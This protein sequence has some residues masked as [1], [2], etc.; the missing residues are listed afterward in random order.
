VMTST[1]TWQVRRL[2][3]GG[4][5]VPAMEVSSGS[6]RGR[7][8]EAESS[9]DKL[10]KTIEYQKGVVT[11]KQVLAS[12]LSH[13]VLHRRVGTGRRWQ[14]LLPGIYLTVTGTPT[15]DQLDIAALLYG[16]PGSTLT[17]VSALRRHGLSN[18]DS[19]AVHVLVPASRQRRSTGYV[20]VHRTRRLPPLVCYEGPVQFA[21]PARAVGDAARDSRDLAD[22][23]AMVAACVQTRRCTVE[24]LAEELATGPIRR[25]RLF[26]AAL[27]EV[28]DGTRSGPE[29]ELRDLIRKGRLPAPMWNPRLYHGT[30]FLARPDAWW[31]EAAVA[32]EVDSRQWHLSPEHWEQTMGRHARMTSLGILV[33]H[34]S[35][36]QIR[37]EPHDVLATIRTALLSRRGQPTPRIRAV[38]AAG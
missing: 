15:R 4:G 20:A 30:T 6:R 23:R 10:A 36:R 31:P 8:C 7:A 32:V 19:S 24:Q 17:G 13:Q 27:A 11:R 34:F 5:N 29:A 2:S 1:P 33:L 16:G 37:E 25:S 22:V 38:P 3:V 9:L 14:R 18:R 12:G 35:P 26:G 28:A 21:L